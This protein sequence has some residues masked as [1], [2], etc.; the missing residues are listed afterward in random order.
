[1]IPLSIRLLH[2]YTCIPLTHNPNS[3]SFYPYPLKLLANVLSLIS[4]QKGASIYALYTLC[5]LYAFM[6]IALKN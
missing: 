5:A 6:Q 1:M 2:N 3:I 4:V